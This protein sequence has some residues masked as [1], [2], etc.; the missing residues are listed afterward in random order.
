MPSSASRSEVSQIIDLHKAP[1][2]PKRSSTSQARSP[3]SSTFT[4]HHHAKKA[5]HFFQRREAEGFSSVLIRE[6]ERQIHSYGGL[7]PPC[8]SNAL[9]DRH[10]LSL[11]SLSM[12]LSLAHKIDR[13]GF[14][15]RAVSFQANHENNACESNEP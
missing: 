2:R 14:G 6:Y 12:R 3:K 4:R 15:N 10:L 13:S 5:I 9:V 11:L 7:D 8:A 1:Q